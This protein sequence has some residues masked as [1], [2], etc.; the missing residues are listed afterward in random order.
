[1][2]RNNNEEKEVKEFQNL[3]NAL[4]GAENATGILYWKWHQLKYRAKDAV[5]QIA[6]DIKKFRSLWQIVSWDCKIPLAV[7]L[8]FNPL[9]LR[10][11]YEE[12]IKF[13]NNLKKGWERK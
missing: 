4:L 11:R 8:I 3:V 1:M 10:E 9:S 6:E 2:F 12:E 7:E 13:H 5:R